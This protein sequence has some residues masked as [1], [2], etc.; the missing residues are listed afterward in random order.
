MGHLVSKNSKRVKKR[1][2]KTRKNCIL[3]GPCML[4]FIVHNTSTL[5][6]DQL[7]SASKLAERY[8]TLTNPEECA[9]FILSPKELGI[10]EERNKNL[11]SGVPA[12]LIGNQLFQTV[13]SEYSDMVCKRKC[14]KLQADTPCKQLRCAGVPAEATENGLSSESA[15]ANPVHVCLLPSPASCSTVHP[16][17]PVKERDSAQQLCSGAGEP[18]A[19]ENMTVEPLNINHLPSSILLKIFSNLSL[20]ERGLC[21]SLVCK[22]WRD[23]CLDFQLWKQLDLSG[24]AQVKDDVLIRIASWIQNLTEINI[25]DCRNVTDKG[26]CFLISKSP[27]LLKYTACRCKQLNNSTL[28]SIAQN[29]HLLQKLHVGNQDKLTDEGLKQIGE[30][31]PKLKDIHFGQCY[32]LSDEGMVAIAKG[33]PNLQRIYMQENKMISHGFL[34]QT[35][36]EYCKTSIYRAVS[37]SL[38]NRQ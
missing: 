15:S 11:L 29:C 20:D 37:T 35:R 18:L 27:G 7:E 9:K 36:T 28:D 6:D 14:T 2:R 34:L 25:S 23:L 13:S 1:R 5:D 38:L 12:K 16:I 4:C 19:C 31:C 30:M 8:A 24:R 32:Q 21:A 10:L 22:Y 33:C 3:H 17:A 26:V